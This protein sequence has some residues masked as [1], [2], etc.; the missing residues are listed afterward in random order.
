MYNMQA[1]KNWKI[2]L[3]VWDA[4]HQ[5]PLGGFKSKE[6]LSTFQRNDYRFL[7]NMMNQHIDVIE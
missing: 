6:Y 2:V 1:A 7:R 5:I 4:G 3:Y